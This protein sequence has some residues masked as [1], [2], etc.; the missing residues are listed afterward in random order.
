MR[1]YT[2]IEEYDLTN[3]DT[4]EIFRRW[5]ELKIKTNGEYVP[6]EAPTSTLTAE[7]REEQKAREELHQEI[8][9]E[10]EIFLKRFKRA[11]QNTANSRLHFGAA[12]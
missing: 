8:I 6:H 11:H 9:R 3:P 4:P 5:I 2:S 12:A 1:R 10:N 7:E